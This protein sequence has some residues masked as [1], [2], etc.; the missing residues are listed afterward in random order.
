[1]TVTP[2]ALVLAG[3]GSARLG[4]DKLALRSG[5]RTLLG[6]VLDGALR[7]ADPVIAIGP[8]VDLGP[9]ILWTREDPPGS[10]PVSAIAAGLAL[11]AAEPEG[12][13]RDLVCLLAGDA[14]RG[15]LAIPALV[16]AL[17]PDVDGCVLTAGDRRQYL[18]SVVRT[19]IVRDRLGRLPRVGASMRELFDGLAIVDVP[20]R[21]DAAADIDT[22]DDARRLGYS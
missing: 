1:M 2:A 22:E 10:G 19:S 3:G 16:A 7:H 13:G 6:E 20:D 17:D 12:I 11:L 15:P 9:R 18:C 14:P 4:R 21:W 5:P 8:A